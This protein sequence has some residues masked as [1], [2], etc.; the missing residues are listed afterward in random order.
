MSAASPMSS[1]GDQVQGSSQIHFR[2]CRECS[3]LLYPKEDRNTNTLMFTCRTC[4]VGEPA[5]SP[6]VYQ[7][8]L[9]NQVG[10][11]AGV[12]QDVGSDPTLPRSN[13]LCPSC[14]ENEAV[15]FQSQQRSAET[16]MKLY[17][18]CCTCGNVFT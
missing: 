10:D 5:S 17:Y 15:F 14:G 1:S 13:K 16:G 9:N 7:N 6:C 8:K 18:V 3:N 12:T 11:T 2:F 4:H